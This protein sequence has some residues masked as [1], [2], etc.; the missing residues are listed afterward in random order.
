M[1]A[2]KSKAY[3]GVV[4][5]SN[6][7]SLEKPKRP[8]KAASALLERALK[9]NRKS[10]DYEVRTKGKTTNVVVRNKDTGLVVSEFSVVGAPKK[11][12]LRKFKPRVRAG[13]IP[14]YKILKAI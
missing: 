5:V 9:E 13:T 3:G 8:T 6:P 11:A 4:I 2:K 1:A 7:K 12:R 10:R 14:I